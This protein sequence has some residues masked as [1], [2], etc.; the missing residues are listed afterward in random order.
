MP[1]YIGTKPISSSAIKMATSYAVQ[2]VNRVYKGE[3]R[4]LQPIPPER[5]NKEK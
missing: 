1:D 4:F 3:E 2:T 5:K